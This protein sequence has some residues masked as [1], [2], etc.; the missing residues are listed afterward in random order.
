[1]EKWKSGKRGKRSERRTLNTE[2]RTSNSKCLSSTFDVQR[3]MFSVSSTTS[4]R[5]FVD[6][7]QWR[8]RRMSRALPWVSE[9]TTLVPGRHECLP[10]QTRPRAWV[11]QAFLPASAEVRV[12][13]P[14]TP[15]HRP[16]NAAT[17]SSFFPILPLSRFSFDCLK[18]NRYPLDATRYHSHIHPRPPSCLSKAIHPPSLHPPQ[19]FK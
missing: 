11:G 4:E 10:H 13:W 9:P 18:L 5:D 16:C 15:V 8:T 3:S 17:V 12:G 6:V 19:M 7:W 2:H 1:M 14:H